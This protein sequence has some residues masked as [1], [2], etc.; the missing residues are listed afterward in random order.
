MAATPTYWLDANVLISAKNEAFRFSVNPAF[1]AHLHKHAKLGRVRVPKMVYDEIVKDGNDEL[2][3]WL[4]ARKADGF[5]IPASKTV[6]DALK[7]VAN[8]VVG[9]YPSHHSAEFLRVADPWIIAHA[10]DTK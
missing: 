9:A 8:H 2:S 6:Q 4:K 1:W 5:C 3:K 10:L 7:V